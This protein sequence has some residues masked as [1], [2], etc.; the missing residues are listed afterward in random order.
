MWSSFV[1][2]R[3][4]PKERFAGDYVFRYCARD[5]GR[6][7]LSMTIPDDPRWTWTI[8]IRELAAV[9]S[10]IPISGIMLC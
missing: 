1:N 7:Y 5:V 10:G 6:T 4:W 8:Y 2:W 9:I 3:A